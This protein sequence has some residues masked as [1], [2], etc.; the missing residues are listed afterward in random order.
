MVSC[1]IFTV[2]NIEEGVKEVFACFQVSF[3]YCR[4]F[5]TIGQC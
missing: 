5:A 1:G 2:D 4:G 3:T